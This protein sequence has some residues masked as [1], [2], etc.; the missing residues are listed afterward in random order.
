M[1]ANCAAKYLFSACLMATA[2]RAQAPIQPDLGKLYYPALARAARIQG[3]VKFTI[4]HGDIQLVSGHPILV[5][6]AKDNLRT[7]APSQSLDAELEVSYIFRLRPQGSV[8]Q[9]EP[10][11]SP[12]SRAFRGLFRM[13][14]TRIVTVERCEEKKSSESI[15][16]F[17]DASEDGRRAAEITIEPEAN[18]IETTDSYIASSRP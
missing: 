8:E 15:K 1:R 18:C 6:V 16:S 4:E 13:P 3:T 17:R 12:V 10:I 14:T 2:L 7:W 11:G 9:E 5:Q